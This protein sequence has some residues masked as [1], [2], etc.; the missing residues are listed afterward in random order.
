MCGERHVRSEL[1]VCG[2]R[3]VRQATFTDVHRERESS[4][5]VHAERA[6]NERTP[7][8]TADVR[9]EPL[10]AVVANPAHV[11]SVCGKRRGP[12]P[13]PCRFGPFMDKN[14]KS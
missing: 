9:G 12:W 6:A 1:D 10:A 2:E 14:F 7:P 5:N 11:R 4:L 13:R 3:N 8:R